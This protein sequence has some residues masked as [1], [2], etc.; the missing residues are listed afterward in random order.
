MLPSLRRII[1]TNFV[2]KRTDHFSS[3]F[4]S[5]STTLNSE[6]DTIIVENRTSNVRL[7]GI[8][9]PHKRNAINRETASKLRQAFEDFDNDPECRVAVLHGFGGTF[10]AGYDL[11]EL[12]NFDEM[13]IEN[14]ATPAPLGPTW[15]LTSKPVVAAI[16]GYA[17]AGGFELALWCDLRVVET[18][19]KM[20]VFCR[21]FGV[22][23]LDGGS[24]RL[25]KL[26]GHSR[27]MDLILTGRGINGKEA[28]DFGIANR[29]VPVGTALGQAFNL[30]HS[31][32]KFPNECLLADRRSAYY[33]TFNSTSLEDALQKE[34]DRS[35]QVLAKEAI[36]GAKRF[37]EGVGKHGKFVLD[38]I[39]YD[40]DVTA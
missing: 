23:L 19:A 37:K 2:S 31:L 24:V 25:S 13:S 29:L 33:S 1:I 5:S 22:P 27:A 39:G 7:I 14:L 4:L 32:V 21:R 38:K 11:E 6:N 34:F 10:C 17:V 12:A 18:T 36:S 16:D 35:K 20:G 8:N 30:A 26:I 9:R 40:V 3:R 28:F 15:M